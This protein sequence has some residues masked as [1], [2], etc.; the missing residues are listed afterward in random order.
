MKLQKALI[1]LFCGSASC[2]CALAL[3]KTLARRLRTASA[4]RILALLLPLTLPTVVQGQFTFVTN[5]GPITIT[6][7]TGPGGQV[8]I[9][10]ETNGLP[11]TG[12][13]TRAFNYCSSVT[14]V[15]VPGSAT[16]IGEYAFDWCGFLTDVTLGN[17][18][19]V[20]SIGTRGSLTAKG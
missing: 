16:S 19:P 18:P 3:T 4:A 13:G 8:V 11:V 5:N 1:G 17:G 14:S 10:G 12:I 20:N 7:Y 15:T 9:P 6:G 2:E